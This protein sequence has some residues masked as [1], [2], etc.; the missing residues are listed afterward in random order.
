MG[1]HF[2]RKLQKH[3]LYSS[4]FDGIRYCHSR[5]VLHRNLKPKHLLV[6]FR[7]PGDLLTA[8]IK[9]ADFALV[10]STNIPVRTYTDEVVTLWYRAP[11]VLMGDKYFLPID[12]YGRLAAFLARCFLENHYFQ[13]SPRLTSFFKFLALWAHQRQKSGKLSKVCRTIRPYFQTGNNNRCQECFQNC[14]GMDVT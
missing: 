13:A 9:I 8:T 7:D 3:L 4:T 12:I 2:R 11:E 10:R 1:K 14:R 6:Q 5:G